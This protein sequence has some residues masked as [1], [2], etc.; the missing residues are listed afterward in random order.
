MEADATQFSLLM[1]M[2]CAPAKPKKTSAVPVPAP[3]A[4]HSVSSAFIGV[5]EGTAVVTTVSPS[6]TSPPPPSSPSPDDFDLT[7]VGMPID[8]HDFLELFS[9]VV[10]SHLWTFSAPSSS[11]QQQQSL[12]QIQSQ[13]KGE[14][15]VDGVQAQGDQPQQQ[16]QQQQQQGQE[17][18]QRVQEQGSQQQEE[19]AS[20]FSA[21]IADILS[22]RLGLF[23]RT[24]PVDSLLVPQPSPVGG[25]AASETA[26]EQQ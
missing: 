15:E 23:K 14:V 4:A 9:R 8:F 19:D 20:V 5:E 1:V 11:Q 3:A 25:R 21:S 2:E 7:C 16:G 10:A 26:A 24:F 13:G 17:E 12:S 22:E 18:Q 6:L